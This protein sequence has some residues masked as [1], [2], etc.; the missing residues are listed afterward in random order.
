VFPGG[1]TK[2]TYC[3][4][5]L[6]CLR[7]CPHDN[8]AINAR[9][10][11]A[12]L[13]QPLTRLDEAYK[14]FIML[15]SAMIYAGVLLGPWGALKNIAYN[16]FTPAWFAYAFAFLGV[17]LVA[18]PGLFTGA[19]SLTSSPSADGRGM[20][21]SFTAFSTALIP[22]GLMFWVAFS[23]SF[24]LTNASY[25]LITLSDPFG[26]GWDLFGTAGF[27]WQPIAASLVAP[28]QTLVLVGGLLWSTRLA[29]R[30]ASER[31]AS[32]IP[33]S[34]FCLAVTLVMLWLLL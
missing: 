1:L 25:I 16:I 21:A 17:I 29:H 4:L 6:E 27:E 10:F 15:G 33:V 26:W 18:L 34:I 5:C 28:V 24:V 23:L 9:P 12:D 2:N 20:R 31:K 11:A 7:T 14:A 13:A 32:A 22:L 30:I 19:L 8:I 3:G